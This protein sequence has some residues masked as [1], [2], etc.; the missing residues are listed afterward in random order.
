VKQISP[1]ELH[2]IIVMAARFRPTCS[3]THG[4][5]YRLLQKHRRSLIYPLSFVTYLRLVI[6]N[7]SSYFEMVLSE[8]FVIF[9]CINAY[10]SL[11]HKRYIFMI[12]Q[13]TIIIQ[14]KTKYTSVLP[15]TFIIQDLNALHLF[16]LLT[17]C[18]ERTVKN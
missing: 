2:N 16:P 3:T 9:Q 10:S 11:Q 18:G 15:L 7:S 1:W 14:I 8:I 4:T 13:R 12:K 6:E 17:V 5:Y